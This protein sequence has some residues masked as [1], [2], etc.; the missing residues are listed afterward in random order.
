[1]KAVKAVSKKPLC[2]C[3]NPLLCICGNEKASQF[4]SFN[5]NKKLLCAEV[6][7][8]N[9]DLLSKFQVDLALIS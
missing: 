6:R 8:S 2:G 1:M 4:L 3:F 5:R 7:L 9:H